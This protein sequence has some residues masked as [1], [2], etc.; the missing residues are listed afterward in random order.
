M[1]NKTWLNNIPLQLHKVLQTPSQPED[2]FQQWQEELSLRQNLRHT[3]PDVY[4]LPLENQEQFLFYKRTFYDINQQDI[5]FTILMN[6]LAD[7]FH[8]EWLAEQPDKFQADFFAALRT[9]FSVHIPHTD[10]LKNLIILFSSRYQTYYPSLL[11]VLKEKDLKF[12]LDKTSNPALRALLLDTLEQIE[13]EN[14]WLTNLF[15]ISR[16][17][18]QVLL[19]KSAQKLNRQL[20]NLDD[21]I[22]SPED[23]QNFLMAGKLEEL[24]PLLTYGCQFSSSTSTRESML[25]FI[26]MVLPLYSILKHP[27]N[28]FNYAQQQ[29]KLFF[30][31]EKN[32]PVSFLYLHLFQLAVRCQTFPNLPFKRE[33]YLRLH[34]ILQQRPSDPLG[35]WFVEQ[36]DILSDETLPEQILQEAKKRLENAPHETW[37]LLEILYIMTAK[38][39]TS[40][41][42]S[43]L[44]NLLSYANALYEWL[45]V[46]SLLP[47]MEIWPSFS[48][49]EGNILFTQMQKILFS[50]EQEVPHD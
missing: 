35:L 5:F 15:S 17:E 34:Q 1:E 43:F 4:E 8:P 45:Q 22:F 38:R 9:Y 42:A 24:M 2:L 14:T 31:D 27:E 50:T 25:S 33:F 28:A 48:A 44:E 40:Y 32:P 12:L 20:K 29:Y 37:A 3:I 19:I 6:H 23:F 39:E 36:Q 46:K 21:E 13:P 49:L 26:L 47:S 16:Q 18:K 7:V 10:E 11:A 41:P 30:P